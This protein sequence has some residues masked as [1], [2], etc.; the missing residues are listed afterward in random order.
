M[1]VGVVCDVV[2]CN[3][4]RW[5]D[6]LMLSSNLGLFL[7]FSVLCCCA[8]RGL[9]VIF[10]ALYCA[11]LQAGGAESIPLALV[12]QLV[13]AFGQYPRDPR[14]EPVWGHCICCCESW[15]TIKH[16]C[17][18]HHLAFGKIHQTQDTL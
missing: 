1:K 16:D 4:L 13:R 2:M 3:G 12:A 5:V 11:S 18:E 9:S 17:S 15:D 8:C 7:L 6:M 10:S 14:F